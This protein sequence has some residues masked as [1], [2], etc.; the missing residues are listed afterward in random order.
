MAWHPAALSGYWFSL[1]NN[2]QKGVFVIN[3]R[4]CKPIYHPLIVIAYKNPAETDIK[5][6]A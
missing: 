2:W 5:S 6:I 3:I 1:K 4:L